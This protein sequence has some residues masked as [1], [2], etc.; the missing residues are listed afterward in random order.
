[1]TSS[2]EYGL[3]T[4][5]GEKKENTTLTKDHTIS[6]SGLA[7]NQ[8]YHFRVKGKNAAGTIFASAD[9]TFQPKSPPSISN[10][11]ILN[12]NEHE[13]TI[14]LKSNVPTEATVSYADPN[15]TDNS[16]S[17]GDGILISEHEIVLKNLV[18]GIT[19]NTKIRVRDEQGTE[20]EI[21]GPDFTTTKDENPPTFDR[22]KTDMALSSNDKV[23]TIIS[24][25]T[26]EPAMGS[27]LYKEGING[28]EKN[29][30][31][32][33]SFTLNHTAVITSFKPGTAYY[34]K[35]Q[36]KDVSDNIGLS[37]NYA[38]LTPRKSQ[39]I[40]QVIIGNFQDIFSWAK[41]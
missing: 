36:S 26:N 12:I 1:M 21:A 23:Q 14:N 39:N 6:L 29:L 9:N 28:E 34:F 8:L 10:I 7:E 22:I 40:V 15:S 30:Q 17:Q 3:T 4:T 19:F 25:N 13:A 33:N 24:W 38:I 5:Y 37:E 16:G 20:T 11:E 31:I 2:V 18:S 32:D 35:A 41:Q 27:I